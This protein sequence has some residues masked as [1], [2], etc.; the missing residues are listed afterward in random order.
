MTD[1]PLIEI[2]GISKRFGGVLALARIELEIHAGEIHGLVGE[3]GAGKSTLGKIVAGVIRP[4]EGELR[5]AGQAVSYHSPRDAL[6]DG[7]TIVEQELALVPAMT[8]AENVVLGLPRKGQ[9]GNSRRVRRY[10]AGLNEEFSLHLRVDAFVEGLSV[11][12]QQKVE[13]LRALVR[14]ARVIVMDEPTGRLSDTEA[15]N[16][17]DIM[18]RLS[19][20]GTTIIYVSH[21]LEEVLSVA[22]RVTVLRNGELIRTAQADE[23]TQETL[24]RAMLGRDA[25]LTFPEKR[26]PE[27]DTPV[28]LSVRELA[29]GDVIPVS[30]ISFDVRAGEIV[31]LA[32]LVGSGRSEVAKILFAAER[33]TGGTVELEGRM[34]QA[35]SPR[36]AIRRGIAL[37]PENRKEQ[38][39]LLRLAVGTNVTLPHLGELTRANVVA[40]RA[41]TRETS[42]IL[43][44]LDVKP[45]N[46]SV[47]TQGLSGGNQQKALFAKWLL[48]PPRVLVA[49][50]PTRGVDVGAK[51]AIYQLLDSLAAEG[52]AILL[53]SSELEEI[54]GLC[55]RVVVMH[56]GRV[57]AELAGDEITEEAVMRLAF[58]GDGD[59]TN[60]PAEAATEERESDG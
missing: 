40:R 19:E 31:G 58:G 35:R 20:G 9:L 18:R 30:G 56:R 15:A 54:L 42:A 43:K 8:V 46:P 34:L 11:G 38:G 47:R 33:R 13:V 17:L 37:V 10:V 48:R 4:D 5:V 22:S 57:M 44:R 36:A 41:E 52:M 39:L 21:F 6:R 51:F 14:G 29:G 32:G 12:D 1:P 27:P 7:V 59:R 24:V 16:L 3:N 2:R 45:A 28:V 55:H 25:S 50:E 23:E 49:D 60:G 53:I 26:P